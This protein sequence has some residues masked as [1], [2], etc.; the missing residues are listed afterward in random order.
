MGERE[1]RRVDH[2]QQPRGDSGIARDD[3]V[4]ALQAERGRFELLQ[5]LEISGRQ[6]W[7]APQ[8]GSELAQFIAREPGIQS[9]APLQSGDQFRGRHRPV[10]EL[11]RAADAFKEER[12]IADVT[13]DEPQCAR[14]LRRD[15]M[16]Q[17]QAGM[18]AAGETGHQGVASSLTQHGLGGGGVRCKDAFPNAVGRGAGRLQ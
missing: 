18:A 6:A 5:Q 14:M 1:R 17:I 10:D 9:Q 12:L 7:Q 4:D 3:F 13:D 16:Q 15:L 8:S 11:V 2:L